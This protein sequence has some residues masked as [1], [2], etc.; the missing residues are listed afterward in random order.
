MAFRKSSGG[1]GVVVATSCGWLLRGE[2]WKKVH[3]INKKN[4]KR[5]ITLVGDLRAMAGHLIV[6]KGM[7]MKHA[8]L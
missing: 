7:R 8:L 5:A 3:Q 6:E 2:D 1:S 4:P